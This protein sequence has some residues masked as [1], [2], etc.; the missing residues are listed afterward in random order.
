M[1]ITDPIA[2]MLTRVRNAGKARFKT[3]EVLPSRINKNIAQVMKTAGYISGYDLKRGNDGKQVLKLY[4]KYADNKRSVISSLQ[5][6]SKP[7]RRV[8]VRSAELPKVLNG[9]GVSIIST[10]RGVVSD[11]EA[12]KLNIGGEVLC[13]IW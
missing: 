10:S 6:I 2:D 11:S 12:R 5:R 7:S 4:L 8:Y 3:V 1:A 13:N 9:Y